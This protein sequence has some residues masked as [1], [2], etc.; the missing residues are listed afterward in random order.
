MDARGEGHAPERLLLEA[1]AVGGGEMLKR[2]VVAEMC[3]AFADF[4]HEAPGAAEWTARKLAAVLDRL[5]LL[6]S[7]PARVAPL[8]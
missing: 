6:E 7:E 1:L 8:F 2:R 5:E 3:R 4:I